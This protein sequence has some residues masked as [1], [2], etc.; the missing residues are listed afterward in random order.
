MSP[1]HKE[2]KYEIRN[3]LCEIDKHCVANMGKKINSQPPAAGSV[4]C[5]QHLL[6]ERLRLSA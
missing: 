4:R 6:S 2:N 5:V 3:K 1:I